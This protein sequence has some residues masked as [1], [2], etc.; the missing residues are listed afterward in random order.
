[1]KRGNNVLDAM[2]VGQFILIFVSLF[3]NGFPEYL[4]NL[5]LMIT[6]AI[7]IVVDSSKVEVALQ[8]ALAVILV[9]DMAQE[10]TRRQMKKIDNRK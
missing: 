8:W 7:L 6:A 5:L 1:M 10:Q 2:L 4:I 3:F 9:I